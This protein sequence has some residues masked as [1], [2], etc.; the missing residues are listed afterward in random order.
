M[1]KSSRQEN[2]VYSAVRIMFLLLFIGS[3]GLAQER[4]RITGMA[5]VNGTKLYYEMTG[6]GKTVVLIH[7]GLVDSRLWDD[8]FK[9]FAGHYLVIRYDL[10]GFGKSAFPAGP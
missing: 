6:K 4:S 7:G 5:P 10:R 3:S 1:M 9:E 2:K 8:Q